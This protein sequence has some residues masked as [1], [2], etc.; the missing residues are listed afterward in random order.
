MTRS[1]RNPASFN[2]SSR[3]NPSLI[4]PGE[5]YLAMCAAVEARRSGVEWVSAAKAEQTGVEATGKVIARRLPSLSVL[6]FSES[7]K[8]EVRE[9]AKAVEAL[10]PR[11]DFDL[12]MKNVIGCIT[13]GVTRPQ[14]GGISVA[15]YTAFWFA[16]EQE[17]KATKP[18]P[19]QGFEGVL[20][21][22]A[23]ASGNLKFPKVTFSNL[24]GIGD[25]RL[26]RAASGA[27][28]GGINITDGKPFGENKFFGAIRP[29]GEFV[30]ARNTPEALRPFLL[31]LAANPA[32]VIADN[33]KKGGNC[34]LCSKALTDERSLA[35]GYGAKCAEH[36]NLP[37]GAV[38]A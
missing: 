29:N 4:S 12:S 37:W 14:I 8:D 36:Y 24:D 2:P 33:G 17:R 35:A 3:R 6:Q 27:N 1:Y 11:S 28:A 9:I 23:T 38:A 31:A 32:K 20:A 21:L 5:V 30:P 15:A 22:F 10:R 25:L 7:V 26:Q 19:E 34:C 16:R 18:A 13:L